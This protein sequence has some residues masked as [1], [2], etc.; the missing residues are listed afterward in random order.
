MQKTIAPTVV[1]GGGAVG[2]ACALYL[3]RAGNEVVLIDPDTPEVRAS[4]GNAG[5]FAETEV[6]PLSTPG[7][8]KRIPKW[9]RD[10]LGPLV[11]RPSHLPAVLPWLLRF[12]RNAR[13]D[14][15][16]EISR[17]MADLGRHMYSGY[18][19][20]LEEASANDLI[21]EGHALRI[22]KSKDQWSETLAAELRRRA[23]VELTEIGREELSVLEPNLSPSF[24]FATK[25]P[26]RRSIVNPGRLL[27]AFTA[28]LRE[29]GGKVITGRVVDFEPGDE[30]IRSA[31]LEGGQLV[32]GSHFVIAAGIWSTPL[33]RRLG[34]YVSMESERGYHVEL[35][36][37]ASLIRGTVVY[38]ARGL[39]M[40]RMEHGLRCTGTVEIAGLSA[41][42]DQRRRD[43]LFDAACEVV[44]QLQDHRS[45]L[46]P[47]WLGHRPST[48]DGL[49]II[50][51]ATRYKNVLYA[52][53][54]GHMGM[55]WAG[56]TG[57]I[58]NQ[59]MQGQN[60]VI[61]TKPLRVKRFGLFSN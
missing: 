16:V 19:P 56:V 33:A 24:T 61:D 34:D 49:P 27:D 10:P 17:S 38:P 54:H 48:P 14:R 32:E 39:A 51:W 26:F 8:L 13:K 1:I 28:N 11:L 4:F 5:Q 25:T 31:R 43:K 36:G 15:V 41:P 47:L 2:L 18:A 23:G 29:R 55:S 52:F 21:A 3:K 58:I 35:P 53:G 57:Q 20:L 50:D 59:M 60:P 44:P 12:L 46:G 9:L 40:S 7:V 37:A 22:F 42:A 30:G 45:S 6:V